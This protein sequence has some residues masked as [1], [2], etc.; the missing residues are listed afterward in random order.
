MPHALMCNVQVKECELLFVMSH[1]N[2][3]EVLSCIH[4]FVYFSVT[5][6]YQWSYSSNSIVLNVVGI[7]RSVT[8]LP[9]NLIL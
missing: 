5:C 8:W 1:I 9:D 3:Y 2:V 6:L 4:I 7:S